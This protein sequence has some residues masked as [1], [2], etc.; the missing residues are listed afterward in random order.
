VGYAAALAT[1]MALLVAGVTVVQI[2]RGE[3]RVHYQ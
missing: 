3:T 2:R 1:L